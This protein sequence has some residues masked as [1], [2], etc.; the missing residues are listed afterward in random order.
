MKFSHIY[1]VNARKLDEKREGEMKLSVLHTC[2]F[3]NNW[4]PNHCWRQ[5]PIM[6]VIV[7]NHGLGGGMK[8]LEGEM[9]LHI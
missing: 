2:Q 3:K 6:I 5:A 7:G 9:K 1:N 8:V 4:R